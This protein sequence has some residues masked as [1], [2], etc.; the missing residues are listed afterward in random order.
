M[1]QTRRD[2]GPQRAAKRR[3]AERTRCPKCG[4]GA[5]LTIG[6]DSWQDAD[7]VTVRATLTVCRWR[8][9]GL[10]DYRAATEE[11]QP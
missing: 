11:P 2:S 5:A 4:R 3:R 8:D 6:Y 7:G 9:R 1:G 10:C